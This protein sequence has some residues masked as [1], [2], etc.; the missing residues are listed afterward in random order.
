MD[1]ERA[2]YKDSDQLDW[3]KL[4]DPAAT[5][6]Y[7]GAHF[8]VNISKEGKPS[9]ISRKPSVK[10]DHLDR[11]LKLPHLQFTLPEYAG[12]QY[13]VELIHTGH[14]KE[15]TES[16]PA[17]SGILN[18]LVEKSLSTQKITGPVRAV[19]LDVKTPHISTY[20]EKLN[21]L[22]E[23]ENAIGKHDLLFTPPVKIGHE[24]VKQLISETR[25]KKEEGVIVTSLTANESNNPRI[26]IKHFVTFNLKVKGITQE[27]DK[28]GTPK[29][30]AGGL[31]V[32]DASGREVATVGTGLTKTLR[33]HIW[34]NPKL[35]LGKPV[36]VKARPN[37]TERLVSPVY[38]GEP[39]GDLDTI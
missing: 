34:E 17:V 13:A 14:S 28:N 10:G 37:K 5:K 8:I 4:E 18:S 31:V 33:K 35:W 36:Q 29:E 16:H 21:H 19:I 24:A 12:N 2:V 27:F 1:Y 7:D 25:D 23:F 9:F 20:Q 3:E 22:K 39:D 15:D 26:K 30:S 38:N 6:K 11:T 32:E